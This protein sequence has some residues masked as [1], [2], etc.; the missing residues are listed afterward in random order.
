VLKKGDK[1]KIANGGR[2]TH[3]YVNN[4]K[5]DG[6]VTISFDGFSTFSGIMLFSAV[7]VRLGDDG[8]WREAVSGVPVN[9]TKA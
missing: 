6:L 5:E 1:V 4:V 7:A 8:H 3:G 9:L 2:T